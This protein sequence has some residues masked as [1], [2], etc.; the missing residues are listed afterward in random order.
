MPP[1]EY[2]HLPLGRI[3]NP[4]PRR[5]RKLNGI[6]L[7][8]RVPAQHAAVL[9]DEI[10]LLLNQFKQEQVNQHNPALIFR[11]KLSSA[12]AVSDQN[13]RSAGLQVL[14]T[15]PGNTAI[16]FSSDEHLQKFLS[17]VEMYQQGTQEG[18][19]NP[20]YNWLAG[21]EVLE[22]WSMEQRLGSKLRYVSIEDEQ[23]Y[24][25]DVEV[26]YFDTHSQCEKRLREL[27]S[28][29]ERNGG[30]WLDYYLGNSLCLARVLV[31]GNLLNQLLHYSI[32]ASID[33]PPKPDLT[34]SSILQLSVDDFAEIQRPAETA[35]RLCIIDS[36]LERGHPFLGAAVGYTDAVPA[37]IGTALDGAGHGTMVAGIA[38]YGDLMP[39]IEARSFTPSINLLSVRVTNDQSQFDDRTLIVNQMRQAIELMHSEYNCRVFNISLGDR[40][41]LFRENGRP[42][43]WATALDE[44]AKEK[45]V[46][47]VV[48]TGNRE[49][50]TNDPEHESIVSDYPNYLFDAQ[51]RLIDPAMAA[52]VLTVGALVYADSTSLGAKFPR[53]PAYQP[54]AQQDQPSP[55]TRC[56]F[57]ME[58]AIKPELCEYGGNWV[59]DGRMKRIGNDLS[60]GI[61]ST[62]HRF[63]QGRLFA[64]D[65]GTSFAAPR[66][67]HQAARILGEYPDASANLVRALLV[68][69][70][71]IPNATK[72]LL[73]FKTPEQK[74]QVLQL[75]G[76][77][78]PQLHNALYST[79]HRVTL[80]REETLSLDHFHIFE[81]PIPE[82]FKQVRGARR[83]SVTLAFDPPVRR[84]RRDYIGTRMSFR[85]IR[86]K[87]LDE[88]VTRYQQSDAK[89]EDF[90]AST[91][92][93]GM[94][95]KYS[96]RHAGTVQ[97]A[98]FEINSK[99][100]LD[101]EHPFYVVVWCENRWSNNEFETQ[102]YAIVVT[103]E[104]LQEAEIALYNIMR[105]QIQLP[106]SVRLRT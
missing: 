32:V 56:G 100:A 82:E 50:P 23:R 37:S 33:L 21:I 6:S 97:K 44:L 88:I 18:K 103:L 95:P 101:Y 13:W 89:V 15:E 45:D 49:A 58:E 80:Y 11:A 77:G 72:D 84:T 90:S 39:G 69:S 54:V 96:N 34:V 27:R 19:K 65:V 70:A 67:A 91:K 17:C 20:S 94:W 22:P 66:V 55:F 78:R 38:L 57:G 61:V 51:S 9:T 102:N 30:T 8:E 106:V 36:G 7:P 31:T 86:G 53:D 83:I 1:A 40:E 98:T 99:L 28:T 92:T 64:V 42:T 3:Q 48:P 24:T 71:A 76:Y 63:G 60:A 46:V 52:N 73:G 62:H 25:V 35:P 41:N 85:L 93:D 75:C 12:G 59:W 68:S 81:V 2:K 79:D 26:W 87:S 105:A 5:K 4:I 74:S 29:I 10:G 104:C 43:Y 16:L 14:S 47:I